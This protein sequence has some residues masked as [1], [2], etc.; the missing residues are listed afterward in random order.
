MAGQDH[1]TAFFTRKRWGRG[2]QYFDSANKKITH[3]KQ[4]KRI[5]ALVIPPM[6]EDVL[7]APHAND[8]IQASGRDAKGRKQYIYSEQ[9]QREQQGLKFKKLK[10]FAKLLPKLRKHCLELVNQSAWTPDKVI[11]L[12][13]LILDQTGIRIGNKHY[14]KQNQTYGLSTL[15]RKHL[16]VDG[17]TITFNFTGKSGK[18]REVSIDDETLASH[19]CDSAQQPGY[20]IFRYCDGAGQWADVSSDEVN[21]FIKV[22]MGEAYTCKDFRTWTGTCLAL[23]QHI[24]LLSADDKPKPTGTKAQQ[25]HVNKVIKAV[26]KELGNTPAICKDYYIHPKILEVITQEKF[27]IT[28]DNELLLQ[29]GTSELSEVEQEVL[30]LID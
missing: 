6:W 21:E 8:K 20:S 5:K 13:V 4:L 14:A 17:D 28:L 1:Q 15:R 16:C 30:R 25:K 12:M 2:F 10:H 9:W 11:A 26:A 18:A 7:I 27:C 23:Q 29:T 22:H 19:I 3:Q 24:R